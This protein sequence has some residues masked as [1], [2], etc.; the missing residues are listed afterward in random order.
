MLLLRRDQP[1]PA[2]PTAKTQSPVPV[3]EVTIT[4][5]GDMIPHTA[6]TRDARTGPSYSYQKMF[7]KIQPMVDAS[8]VVFCNQE[9]LSAGEQFGVS[10]YPAFNAPVEFSRDL[11]KAGCNTINLANNHMADK[12]REA[13]AASRRT[14]DGLS[15]LAV[16][17]ANRSNDE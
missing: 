17:G 10:G 5:M 16:S 2:L 12:G 6:L 1:T 9:G 8:G 14:W 7:Q 11:A 13:I 15:T 3:Q 4:A